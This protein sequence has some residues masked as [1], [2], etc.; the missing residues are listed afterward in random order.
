MYNKHHQIH[1]HCQTTGKMKNKSLK[2]QKRIEQ[3]VFNLN[4]LHG[5]YSIPNVQTK[6]KKTLIFD[7]Y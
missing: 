3:Y 6:I 1:T 5:T 2:D 4:Q 7:H